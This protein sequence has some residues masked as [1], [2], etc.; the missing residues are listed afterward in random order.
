MGPAATGAQHTGL[1]VSTTGSALGIR[2][3]LPA[4]LTYVKEVAYLRLSD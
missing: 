4:A 1:V 3:I 2:Q